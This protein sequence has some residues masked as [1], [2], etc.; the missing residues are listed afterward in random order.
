MKMP[1]VTRIPCRGVLRSGAPCRYKSVDG[2]CGFHVS[3][4][5]PAVDAC[6]SQCSICLENVVNAKRLQCGHEFHRGCIDQWLAT[7][8]TCPNCRAYVLDMAGLLSQL[9]RHGIV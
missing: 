8:T 1:R 5:V 3:Q 2:Y 7:H 6:G 9:A 4:R